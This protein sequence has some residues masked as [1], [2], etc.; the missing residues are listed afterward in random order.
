MDFAYCSNC[1]STHLP[2]EHTNRRRSGGR[3]L[4]ATPPRF[5]RFKKPTAKASPNPSPPTTGEFAARALDAARQV[6][7]WLT[8]GSER[9]LFEGRRAARAAGRTLS[10]GW[11]KAV[12]FS[13]VLDVPSQPSRTTGKHAPVATPQSSPIETMVAV[14]PGG[15][16]LVEYSS[17]R[18]HLLEVSMLESL[19][20]YDPATV[21]VA[22]S[23]PKAATATLPVNKPITG[24]APLIPDL[25]LVGWKP[26]VI[27]RS[28]LN[29]GVF[30]LTTVGVVAVATVVVVTLVLAVIRTP[31]VSEARLHQNL[32]TQATALEVALTSLNEA[33][34]SGNEIGA[35]ATTAL[36][37]V[38]IA[39]RGLFEA[40]SR[41]DPNT[42]QDMRSAAIAVA[43]RSLDLQSQITEALSYRLVL[44][45]LWRTPDLSAVT[46]P[47]DAA[48]ALAP[49]Q[50]QIRDLEPS[51]PDQGS[52]AGHSADVSTFI[53]EIDSWAPLY[54]DALAVGDTG[55]AA[56]ALETLESRL[57]G[58]AHSAEAVIAEVVANV[59]A[60][61]QLLM[62]D[63]V[64]LSG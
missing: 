54:L 20:F 17:T 7:I 3:H 22:V 12:E 55:A 24:R 27:A 51:L 40:A 19:G 9:A 26:H 38:D 50:A 32:A 44:G 23:A 36:V 43:E 29:P 10:Q 60:E 28:K 14:T 35:E 56:A 2:G 58:L 30:R 31:Q 63:L 11:S 15:V 52:L 46:V 33:L 25:D 61:S 21:V 59:Q 34:G 64:G 42:D 6:G 39:S 57:A 49:W 4:A 48:E 1:R 47:A 62:S 53:R 5:Q 8:H 37:D 16:G 41:L 13:G 45:P 18:D